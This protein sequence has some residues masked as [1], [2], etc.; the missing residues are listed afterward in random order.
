MDTVVKFLFR[1]KLHK[2]EAFI[3]TTAEPCLIFCLFNDKELV[4]EF[5]DEVTIKTDYKQLLPKKDDYTELVELRQAI[6]NTVKNMKEFQLLSV[7]LMQQRQPLQ[8]STNSKMI[9]FPV[10]AIH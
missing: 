6:F 3:D 5:G 9:S 10:Y 8:P 1:G 4:A 2:C 7:R